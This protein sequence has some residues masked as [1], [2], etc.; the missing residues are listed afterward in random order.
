MH[1]LLLDAGLWA[2]KLKSAFK[3]HKE[4]HQVVLLVHASQIPE[5][6]NEIS[7]NGRLYDIR[8]VHPKGDSVQLIVER[9]GE[10]EEV[11][12]EQTSLF[13]R[14]PQGT[15]RFARYKWLPPDYKLLPNTNQLPVLFTERIKSICYGLLVNSLVSPVAS[16]VL[17][18]PPEMCAIL[19]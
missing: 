4:E 16:S 14:A 6:A 3:E 15:P 8:A 12:Q 2:C 11:Q 1:V 7:L 9:D 17:K 10:E 5:G 19:C 18:P 13:E